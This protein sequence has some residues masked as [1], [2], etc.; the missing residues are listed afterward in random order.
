MN[1]VVNRQSRIFEQE[2][3]GCEFKIKLKHLVT[4]IYQLAFELVPSA[5]SGI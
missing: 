1:L 5:S 4:W 3:V 2:I